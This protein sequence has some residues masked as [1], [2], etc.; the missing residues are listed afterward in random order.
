MLTTTLGARCRTRRTT[1]GRLASTQ[2]TAFSS[3]GF[4]V[5]V[6]LRCR[7]ASH[8]QLGVKRSPRRNQRRKV[9]GGLARG[10]AHARK[11]QNQNETTKQQHSSSCWRTCS[12]VGIDNPGTNV[13]ALHR[14]S[15]AAS[16]RRD[17][18]RARPNQPVGQIRIR[19]IIGQQKRRPRGLQ[20]AIG[21]NY[22]AMRRL[23]GWRRCTSEEQRTGVA[24]TRVERNPLPTRV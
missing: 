4:N 16:R 18:M 17:A 21:Q 7:D 10:R 12:R 14:D 13:I 24:L 19:I 8:L 6:C 11:S 5:S 23:F 1:E 22:V 15:I 20:R 2:S 9:G 3:N